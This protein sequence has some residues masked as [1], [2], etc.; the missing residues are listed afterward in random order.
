MA[1]SI[2]SENIRN[3]PDDLLPLADAPHRL[4]VGLDD[5]RQA[6]AVRA[7][8]PATV[9]VMVVVVVSPRLGPP[10]P[11]GAAQREAVGLGRAGLEREGGG[12]GGRGEGEERRRCEGCEDGFDE[13]VLREHGGCGLEGVGV[14]V[15]VGA[16]GYASGPPRSAGVLYTIYHPVPKPRPLLGGTN[17]RPRLPVARSPHPTARVG[18]THTH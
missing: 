18:R 3:A 7:A 10:R 14:G 17:L 8:V 4:P 9:A 12:R 15:D 1:P 11:E 5:L 13:G 2:R 6:V 16:S